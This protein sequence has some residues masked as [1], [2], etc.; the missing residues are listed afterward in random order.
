[1]VLTRS[2]PPGFVWMTYHSLESSGSIEPI[3][4]IGFIEFVEFVGFIEF[5]EFIGS[6]GFVG[7]TL[8]RGWRIAPAFPKRL[9]AGRSLEV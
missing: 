4:F 8:V 5:V 6:I 1:L 7:S 3:G 9:R 2:S